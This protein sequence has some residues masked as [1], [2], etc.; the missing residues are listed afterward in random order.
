MP[1]RYLPE[2]PREWLNRARSDLLLARSERDGIYLR[3][4]EA[5][6]TS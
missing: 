1:E 2:D 6:S 5:E 3:A 4:K